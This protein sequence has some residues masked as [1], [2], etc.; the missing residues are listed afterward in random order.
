MASAVG[1]KAG[2][3]ILL[4]NTYYFDTVIED[5]MALRGVAYNSAKAAPSPEISISKQTISMRV[6]A[7]F[8][9]LDE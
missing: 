6:N 1:S 9:L 5:E 8:E 3:A 4:S 7:K 2:K